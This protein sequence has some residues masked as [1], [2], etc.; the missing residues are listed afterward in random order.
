MAT[1]RVPILGNAVPDTSGSVYLV[2]LD[3]VASND[4]WD[5][6]VW[7]FADTATR[8][9][10]RGSVSV[11]KNYNASGTTKL[12]IVWTASATSGDVEW[13]CDY[14]AVGGNDAESLDQSGTQ[15]SVNLNDTAPGAAWRRM[16][17]LI[18]LTAG[19]LLADDT[20]QFELFRDGTDGGDTIS[21]A[22]YL[23]DLLLEYTD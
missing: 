11:P 7:A 1:Y 16:E 2:P 23:V 20:L 9:G 13:D 8:I 15:E 6:L 17:C 18:T 21:G 19:N 5:H 4:I 3:A 10:L 14:R 12:I 22:V